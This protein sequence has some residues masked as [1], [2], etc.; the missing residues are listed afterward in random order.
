MK[1]IIVVT[2]ISLILFGCGQSDKNVKLD[3]IIFHTSMCFG[4]C[5]TFHL[6]VDN[7]RE[8]KLYAEE[9]YKNPNEFSSFE[10]DTTKTGY[11]IG[12]VADTIFRK[13]TN[14]LNDLGLDTLEFDGASCC[15]GS[16]ITIIVYYNG[17]RKF[18][19]SMFPPYKAHKLIGTL[20]D[21]CETSKLTRTTE[22][23]N[24]EDEN[25]SR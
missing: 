25:A 6:Q 8:V 15:D 11:F 19:K 23:F 4:T 9:V 3:K 2:S 21:I 17:K 24:I 14:E 16:L 7:N 5:P 20:Y 1:R 10:I 13:L 18:L 22:K 12:I